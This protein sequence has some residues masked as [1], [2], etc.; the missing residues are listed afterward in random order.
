[1]IAVP[2]ALAI[3]NA[4]VERHPRY[5]YTATATELDANGTPQVAVIR[6]TY[7]AATNVETAHVMRGR[8]AGADVTYAGGTTAD[9]RAPGIAHMFSVRLSVRD[10]RIISPRGNDARVGIFANVARCFAADAAH[11]HVEGTGDV[12]TIVDDAPSCTEGYGA[13]PVTSDRLVLGDDGQPLERDRYDGATLVEKW[14][15]SDLQ[16]L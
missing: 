4:W 16:A 3:L 5:A 7:D 9:V 12:V 14:T 13:S 8:M 10:P 15:I 2:G 1:M 6:L 11:L